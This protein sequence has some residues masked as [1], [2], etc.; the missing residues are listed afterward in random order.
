VP[1]FTGLVGAA[2]AGTAVL[3]RPQQTGQPASALLDLLLAGLLALALAYHARLVCPPGARPGIAAAILPLAAVLSLGLVLDGTEQAVV[4]GITVAVTILVVA[5]VP[6]LEA[7]AAAGLPPAAS[8]R[9][10]RVLAGLAVAVPVCAAGAASGLSPLVRALLVLAGTGAAALDG[11]RAEGVRSGWA[12]PASVATAS[13]T[14][15]GSLGAPRVGQPVGAVALLLL[16]YGARG[17]LGQHRPG[18]RHA[19]AL[20]EYGAFAAA[21]AAVLA[22]AR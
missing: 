14:A 22:S 10:A 20:V 2:V 7:I 4:G 8:L 13:V 17:L 16:W 9:G 1:V 18:R 21:A 19:L 11:M 5:L 3:V 12:V 15:V 6:H